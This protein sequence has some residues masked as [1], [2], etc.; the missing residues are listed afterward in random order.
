M[1]ADGDQWLLTLI[2]RLLTLIQRLPTPPPLAR[3]GMCC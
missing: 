1:A 3:R 2:Q